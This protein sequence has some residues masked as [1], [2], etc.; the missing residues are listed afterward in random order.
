MYC[1]LSP[2]APDGRV[3]D[4]MVLTNGEQD[5]ELLGWDRR[6][7]EKTGVFAEVPPEQS[8][9]GH[10]SALYADVSRQACWYQWEA[11][12]SAEAKP[13]A[14][15]EGVSVPKEASGWRPVPTPEGKPVPLPSAAIFSIQEAGPE[16]GPAPC[17][18]AATG[19]APDGEPLT[20]AERFSVLEALVLEREYQEALRE[21]KE[22]TRMIYD[23]L[24]SV[25]R[26][27]KPSQEEMEKKLA[28]FLQSGRITQEQY[29][30]LTELAQSI[31]AAS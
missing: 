7:K 22:G 20:L 25:I 16:A 13:A 29:Q 9:E 10:R 6:E 23:L 28:V 2:I 21:R 17:P 5:V 24:Q 31:P 18:E 27:G 12:P 1:Y 30:E 8:W 15:P 3:I 19:A 26:L 14:G 11:V 4:R